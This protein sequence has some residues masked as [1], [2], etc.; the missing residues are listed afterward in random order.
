MSRTPWLWID[1]IV[2]RVSV[3]PW[4]LSIA[5]F[6]ALL[7][8]DSLITIASGERLRGILDI[9]H[10]IVLILPAFGSFTITYVRQALAGL[11]AA[12]KPWL[13]NS[14]AESRAFW[15]SAPD[16]LMCGFWPFAVAWVVIPILYGILHSAFQPQLVGQLG[17][18]SVQY[19]TFLVT[20]LTW[21]FM[22][23]A[24]SIALVGLGRLFHELGKTLDLKEDFVLRGAKVVLQ[25]FNSLI[26]VTCI[27]VALPLLLTGMLPVTLRYV[28]GHA[29]TLGLMDLVPL[30]LLA[31]VVVL[32]IAVPQI[33]MNRF[34]SKE[35]DKALADI[36]EQM[37]QAIAVPEGASL[38]D[39]L[40]RMHHLQALVYM[41]RKA[42]KFNPTLV[43]AKFLV[44]VAA[45]IGTVT[46][47]LYYL[48]TFIGTF[49][50]SGG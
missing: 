32:T 40:R 20:P 7:A 26:W 30:I 14:E 38:E 35:K 43:D 15:D 42:E 10:I 31:I 29:I 21:Y 22:G 41:E 46:Y 4:L 49:L 50:Q 12:V 33:F 19:V 39:V 16:L 48:R 6:L 17:N 23:G 3:P 24:T 1:L 27:S 44:Q 18:R 45:S 13:T 9:R 34:L 37:S 2:S 47:A 11:E 8:I 28:S 36:S 25:P 5:L